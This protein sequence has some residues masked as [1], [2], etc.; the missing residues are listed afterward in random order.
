M[1]LAQISK[2]AIAM[3][4]FTALMVLADQSAAG[5]GHGK[6]SSHGSN[7]GSKGDP[8]KIDRVIEVVMTE[9]TYDFSQLELRKG[10]TVRFVIKNEGEFLHEFNIGT[11]HMH[12]EHRSEMAMM[13]ENGMMDEY[14][15]LEPMGHDDPNAVIVEPGE[16]KALVWTFSA[17]GSFEFAC[18]IP[19]HY[20]TGMVG[21]LIV[22]PTAKSS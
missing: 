14:R 19:G 11:S 2:S 18:N 12:A 16:T 22:L 13:M 4:G 10:E 5:P 1:T 17:E 20:E 8:S 7:V 15:V 6:G 3:L 21:K 9:N